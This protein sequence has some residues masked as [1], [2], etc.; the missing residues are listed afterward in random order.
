MTTTKKLPTAKVAKRLAECVVFALKHLRTASRDAL[1]I[2]LKTGD[3]R[4]WQDD[5][6]D[7]LDDYGYKIDREKYYAALPKKRGR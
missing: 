2:D 7:A 3:C 4:P 6:M 1:M 5:F